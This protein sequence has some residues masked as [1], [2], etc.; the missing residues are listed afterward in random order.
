MI[1][2]M[3]VI[4][5]LVF[6]AVTAY[7]SCVISGRCSEGEWREWLCL[8]TNDECTGCPYE[9]NAECPADYTGCWKEVDE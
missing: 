8:E 7:A 6:C 5:I 4:G 9:E 2:A 1:A 3:T